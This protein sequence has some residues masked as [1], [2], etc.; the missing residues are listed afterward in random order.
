MHS[1]SCR[2][3]PLRISRICLF[4]WGLRKSYSCQTPVVAFAVKQVAAAPPVEGVPAAD[5]AGGGTTA[6]TAAP[7]VVDVLTSEVMVKSLRSTGTNAAV[8]LTFPLAFVPTFFEGRNHSLLSGTYCCVIANSQKLGRA[9]A[10]NTA[11]TA[12]TTTSSI[13]EKPFSPGLRLS[14][15]R[16]RGFADRPEEGS[17]RI[18]NSFFMILA[19]KSVVNTVQW[20]HLQ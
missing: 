15:R 5:P 16:V 14:A 8:T 20:A 2:L 6:G 18:Q 3:M 19:L 7:G 10:V 1:P 17:S 12:I 9:M 13:R 11:S 4:R